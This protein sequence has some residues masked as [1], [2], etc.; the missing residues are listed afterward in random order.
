MPPRADYR[1]RDTRN[2]RRRLVQAEPLEPRLALA[3]PPVSPNAGSIVA[4]QFQPYGYALLGTQLLDVTTKNGA[5]LQLTAPN[6]IGTPPTPPID[7]GYPQKPVNTGL[8]SGSQVN[9]GGFS[10]VGL[11]LQNVT[12][13][14]G[15]L[16]VDVVDE[17]IGKPS[18]GGTQPVP[19]NGRQTRPCCRLLS[20]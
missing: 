16:R 15:G 4:S 2:S 11:Q 20:F 6:N 1:R 19:V 3:V 9:V 5:S 8:I 14:N 7:Y 18:A 12:L 10:T 13:P 17:G